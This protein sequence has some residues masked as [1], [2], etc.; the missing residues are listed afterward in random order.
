MAR[1]ALGPRAGKVRSICGAL[2]LSIH[3]SCL[4]RR[5]HIAA[6]RPVVRIDQQHL[7]NPRADAL[8]GAFLHDL[9]HPRTASLALSCGT[10]VIWFGR[11][12]ALHAHVSRRVV[13]RWRWAFALA[14]SALVWIHDYERRARRNA[15]SA[16]GRG[17]SPVFVV[18]D[19]KDFAIGADALPK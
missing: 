5:T 7:A 6:L 16:T 12:G 18:G 9:A 3:E 17:F 8:S 19:N 4:W 14:T 1:E 13:V 10:V 11:I 15:R 2:A